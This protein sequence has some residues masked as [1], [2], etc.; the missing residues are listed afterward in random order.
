MSSLMAREVPTSEPTLEL[1]FRDIANSSGVSSLNEAELS[2]R[3]KKGDKKAL[4][5]LVK[6]N[7]RFVVSVAKK[8]QNQGLPLIDLISEGNIGL[9]RAAEKFDYKKNFKFISYA[10][11]W[12]R[13][14]ILQA[15]A[16]QSRVVRVPINRISEISI[17]RK[18]REELEQKYKQNQSFSFL[19]EELKKDGFKNAETMHQIDTRPIALDTPV[20]E[21]E[22]ATYMDA[23]LDDSAPSPD[24]FVEKHF[25]EH[26]SAKY[27]DM[28]PARE[29]EILERYF[30]FKDDHAQTL[31]EIG[32][33][34]KLTRERVRQLKERGL[35]RLRNRAGSGF[36]S[37]KRSRCIANA[38][39][40]NEK[41]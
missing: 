40:L 28:L 36:E 38:T 29:R 3:I 19:M 20:L 10:V 8:Y 13:Q 24:V 41:I 2:H 25:L 30:G 34:L 12:I 9:I 35:R 26:E 27:L 6:A 7:L 23:L 18:K 22:Q 37:K 32:K 33:H 31:E 4:D 11:W 21:G 16:E 5:L 1:Y 17:I 15:L 39:K 14:A